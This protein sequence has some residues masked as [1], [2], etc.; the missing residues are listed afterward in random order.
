[1]KEGRESGILREEL[2]FHEKREW[3]LGRIKERGKRMGVRISWV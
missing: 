1:M 2:G 3:W